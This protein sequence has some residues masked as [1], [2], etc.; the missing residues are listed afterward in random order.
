MSVSVAPELGGK[1]DERAAGSQA[2]YPMDVWVMAEQG[3][4]LPLG[5]YGDSGAGMSVPDGAQEWCSEED[6]ADRAEA[7]HQNV[8][9]C[10]SV[11]HGEK[12]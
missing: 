11:G 5:Q 2:E 3:D 7:N 10:G 4:I 9:R 12:L 6:V 8:R 1:S